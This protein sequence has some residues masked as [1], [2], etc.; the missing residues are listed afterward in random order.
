[1]R[2]PLI[3]AALLMLPL[4]AACSND[5]ES[6]PPGT[7]AAASVAATTTATAP[8]PTSPSATTSV[9][10]G[11]TTTSGTTVSGPPLTAAEIS[12]SLQDKGKLDAKTA[13][14]IAAVYIDEGISQPGLR[15]ILDSDYNSAAISP[16]DLGLTTSDIPKVAK[17]TTR[18]VS[19]CI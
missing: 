12:E 18:V 15:K 17:A 14:C 2:K 7:T 10:A 19:E 16:T 1:M 6:A 13:D 9:Q 5:Q 8:G 4:L 3:A 11:A